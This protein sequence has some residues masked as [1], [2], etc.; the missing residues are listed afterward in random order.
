[1]KRG[2]KVKNRFHVIPPSQ[3]ESAKIKGK[4]MMRQQIQGCTLI[5]FNS[6]ITTDNY[7]SKHEKQELKYK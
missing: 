7:I 5:L 3:G 1:M 6:S 2:E 4:A